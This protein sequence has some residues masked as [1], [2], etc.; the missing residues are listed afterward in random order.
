M[1]ANEANADIQ[2]CSL[3]YTAVI[4]DGDLLCHPSTESHRLQSRSD[5]NTPFNFIL[6]RRRLRTR[7]KS[8]DHVSAVL[9]PRVD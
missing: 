1:A 9:K 7:D 3:R 6:L 8:L 4:V 5:T 2:L